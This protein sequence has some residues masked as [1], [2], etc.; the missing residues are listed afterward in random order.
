MCG[1]DFVV[2]GGG[3]VTAEMDARSRS[4]IERRRRRRRPEVNTVERS[5]TLHYL[6]QEDHYSISIDTLRMSPITTEAY[7]V[8]ENNGPF[9]LETVHYSDVG[10]HELL[11]EAV[12]VSLCHTDV[13]A[14]G[15]SFMMKP[16][17]L[18]GHEGSGIGM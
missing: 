8:H 12:A 11:V 4:H 1:C 15:G 10:E 6:I 13:L 18:P 16:P 5:R 9:E 2:V 14:S 3:D 17:F 7:V